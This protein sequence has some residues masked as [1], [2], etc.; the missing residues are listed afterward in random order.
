MQWRRR[1]ESA[2]PDRAHETVLPGDRLI[3]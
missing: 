3:A 2:C 1:A